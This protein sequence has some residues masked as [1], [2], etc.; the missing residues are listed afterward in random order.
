MGDKTNQQEEITN[1]KLFAILDLKSN[2]N[3]NTAIVEQITNNLEEIKIQQ[4]DLKND[5][6]YFKS[7]TQAAIKALEASQQAI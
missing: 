6:L 2:L 7:N 4:N 3:K 5:L 1:S